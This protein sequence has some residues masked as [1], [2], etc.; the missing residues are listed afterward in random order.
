MRQNRSRNRVGQ[1]ADIAWEAG[2]DG[3]TFNPI[4]PYGRFDFHRNRSI[5]YKLFYRI[6]KNLVIERIT[7]IR[8]GKTANVRWG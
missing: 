2:L 3:E 7:L 5:L 1:T 6:K 8:S 4:L